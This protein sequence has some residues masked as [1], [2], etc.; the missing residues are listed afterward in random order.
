MDTKKKAI[1]IW[2]DIAF[3]IVIV[4]V[5]VVLALY[6]VPEETT[7]HP[8]DFS[9]VPSYVEPQES[10]YTSPWDTRVISE[11]ISLSESAE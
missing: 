2:L 9:S 5:A 11:D 10:A 8:T 3:G 4:V 6:V 7:F 1:P